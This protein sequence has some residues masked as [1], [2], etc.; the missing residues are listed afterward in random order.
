[1]ERYDLVVVGGGPGG[2]P[3]A[4]RAAELGMSVALL[5]PRGLGGECTLYGCVPSKAAAFYAASLL[6]ARRVSEELRAD[7]IRVF[8][9]ARRVAAELSQ[10]IEGLLSRLGVEVLREAAASLKRMGEW[11]LV[12][13]SAGSEL[14]AA[15]VLLAPGTEPA[16]LGWV[17]KGPRVLDNRGLLDT[18]PEPGSSVLIV[19]GGAVGVEY[20]AVLALLGYRVTLA[21]ALDRLLPGFPRGLSAYASRLLSRLGVEVLKRCPLERVAQQGDHIDA[22][23]CAS[24]R[25]F[26]YAVIAVGRKP[27]TGWL[28]GS[29]VALTEKGFIEVNERLETGLPGVFAAGDAAGPPLLAHKAISQSIHVAEAAA[30]RLRGSEPRAWSPGPI[31]MVAHVGGVELGYVGVAAEEA[32]RQG[33]GVARIRLGWSLHARLAGAEDGY[34]SLTYDPDTGRLMGLEAAA[35]GAAELVAEA[36]VAV[37]RGLRLEELREVIHPHPERSEALLEAV[38]AALGEPIHYLLGARRS[39]RG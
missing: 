5:E 2:Y 15:T 31:P 22:R 18:P 8:E 34:V 21:E 32:R 29:G 38:H 16:M 27:T 11:Y 39:T 6:A 9:E 26:D 7:P 33:L 13:G 35:P 12:R 1:V 10:G 28:R 17:E 19:G 23:L 37:A 36:A 14:G 4:V 25:R 20:A 30:A 24:T 3:A